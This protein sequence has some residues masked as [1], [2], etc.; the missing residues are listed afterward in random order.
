MARSGGSKAQPQK[1]GG[2]LIDPQPKGTMVRQHVLAGASTVGLRGMDG[3]GM[4]ASGRL[5]PLTRS[6]GL[7]A[8]LGFGLCFSSQALGL[9][10]QEVFELAAS[11]VSGTSAVGG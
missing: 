11:L 10:K 9:P 6:R 3:Q 1:R 8:A 2:K 4:A 7:L 5:S